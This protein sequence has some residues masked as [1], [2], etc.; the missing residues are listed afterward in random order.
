VSVSNGK[1]VYISGS[2]GNNIL[3]GLADKGTQS[4]VNSYVAVTTQDF[5]INE[6]GYATTFG[7]VQDI[8]T[9]T[10]TEGAIVYLNTSGTLTSTKPTTGNI[11]I[12]G[13]C[14]RSHATQGKIFV[15]VKSDIST[16]QQVVDAGNITNKEV[17]F[18]GTAK[19]L[20]SETVFSVKKD[21]NTNWGRMRGDGVLAFQKGEISDFKSTATT[22]YDNF[23]SENISYFGVE[24]TDQNAVINV[25]TVPS[26]GTNGFSVSNT[27]GW[28]KML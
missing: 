28:S 18:D 5:T 1:V 24:N 21:A 3:V 26:S 20:A 10:L 4:Y 17:I 23:H 6:I 27:G 13:I 16:L 7:L 8:N 19:T 22:I 9:S 11:I 2:N 12:I 25:G 14:A 15:S